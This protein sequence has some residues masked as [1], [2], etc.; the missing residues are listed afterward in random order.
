[1]TDELEDEEQG[2]IAKAPGKAEEM[3]AIE[4]NRI[5]E[6]YEL[7]NVYA[8]DG[9]KPAHLV[10]G[11]VFVSRGDVNAIMGPSGRKWKDHA[12]VYGRV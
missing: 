9:Q 7:R 5:E 10:D 12:D 11:Y 2:K 3:V 1:M 6:T 8:R 4:M